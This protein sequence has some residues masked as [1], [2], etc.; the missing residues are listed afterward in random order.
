MTSLMTLTDR[1][2]LARG[3][4]LLIAAAAIAAPD[5]A[6][7]QAA[8]GTD[9]PNRSIRMVVP[10]AP[11][12]ATDILARIVGQRL[13]E[14]WGQ[15][16]VID[17]RAGAGGTV[18]AAIAARA[19]P[20]GYTLVMGTNG[21]HAIGPSLYPK[22][23]Y[24]AIKD[25]AP[26]TL[27]AHVPQALMVHPSLPVKDIKDLIAYAKERPGQLNFSSAGTGTPGHLG[28]ELMQIMAGI[29]MVHVP[30]AGGAPGLAALVGGQVQLMAD[31]MNSALPMI[32]AGKVRAI[33]VTTIKRSVALPEMATVAEQ[34]LTGFDSG[35]WFGLFAPAGTPPAI[36]NRLNAEV[37]K[38][39]NT[40]EVRERMLQQGAEPAP[41]TPAQFTQ[42]IRDDT[43][44][45]AKVIK[46]SG[47]KAD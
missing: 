15:T 22:L 6:A 32:K 27:V 38:I 13:T 46:L 40:P 34:G 10:F 20:D 44:R 7:A 26:I 43:A 33:A 4:A 1:A 39:L 9:Y 3:V 30:F 31:N 42:L 19:N 2:H 47:A 37:V 14:L 18:G 45:W 41:G 5:S 35:S 36:I 12:G 29:K 24:D 23:T 17:N 8:A 11:G 16:V 21:S 28:L 25:F